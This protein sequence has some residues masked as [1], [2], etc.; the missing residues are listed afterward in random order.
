MVACAGGRVERELQRSKPR[1][2]IR[3]LRHLVADHNGFGARLARPIVGKGLGAGTLKLALEVAL[4]PAPR[5][6]FGETVRYF[7]RP[8]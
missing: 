5:L 2:F 1:Y 6:R 7:I 8:R 3:S 4:L